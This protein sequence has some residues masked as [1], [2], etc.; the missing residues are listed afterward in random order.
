MD[1]KHLKV[2]SLGPVSMMLLGTTLSVGLLFGGNTVTAEANEDVPI[3]EIGT[4]TTV[5][6]TDKQSDIVNN[7]GNVKEEEAANQDNLKNKEAYENDI[8]TISK[9][10]EDLL[11]LKELYK[12][13]D[14]TL[15]EDIVELNDKI[16]KT[17]N[18]ISKLK[19]SIKNKEVEIS[20]N[21]TKLLALYEEIKLM[22]IEKI[23]REEDFKGR[24][25]TIQKNKDITLVELLIESKSF[26]D[27][28]NR[29][30]NYKTIVE[31]DNKQIEEYLA[32]LERLDK[33]KLET[34]AIKDKLEEDLK[35]LE[36]EKAKLEIEISE[37]QDLKVRKERQSMSTKDILASIDKD[38]AILKN[39]KA[40]LEQNK[41]KAVLYEELQNRITKDISEGIANKTIYKYTDLSTREFVSNKL[42]EEQAEG[43]I[44]VTPTVGTFTS[45]YGPRMLYGAY[46][47]HRGIDLANKV[48]T[49]VISS[50]EG[51]VIFAGA[52]GSYGNVIFIS[53]HIDGIDYVTVYAH[54]SAIGVRK[55]DEVPQGQLIGLMG[56]T[57]N[58][59]GSHL[60]F[61]IQ[62]NATE[63]SNK[64]V[65]PWK[66]LTSELNDLNTR[67]KTIAE[68]LNG[69]SELK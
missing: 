12:N 58:S 40:T 17:E 47:F 54:L 67:K 36:T 6:L 64:M 18:K 48:G 66:Y 55:G 14:S 31:A 53:H 9:N 51:K 61:E 11:N 15:K 28:I 10:I 5:D 37:L 56:S 19:E 38:I 35:M 3:G 43:K 59:T 29:F 45:G 34:E 57:G 4:D 30:F 52:H 2:R 24:I 1:N 27:M 23:K 69:I 49:P 44:F 50:A 46:D 16:Q 63:W 60:H 68:E 41:N 13:N 21:Q 26:G 39:S 33:A 62:V 7:L 42:E 25:K 32:L 65:D 20:E 22:E 8:K